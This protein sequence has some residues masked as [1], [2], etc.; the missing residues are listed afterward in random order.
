MHQNEKIEK[1]CQ[2]IMKKSESQQNLMDSLSALPRD[3]RNLQ[4]SNLNNSYSFDG[5]LNR[6]RQN[7]ADS[8][9]SFSDLPLPMR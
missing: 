7:E 6:S 3:Y 8:I 5:G 9:G 2:E 4:N 1:H